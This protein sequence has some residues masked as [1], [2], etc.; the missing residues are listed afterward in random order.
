MD[1]GYSE[2]G[3]SPLLPDVVRDA[4]PLDATREQRGRKMFRIGAITTG[5]L[6]A[7]ALVGVVSQVSAVLTTLRLCLSSIRKENLPA[8]RLPARAHEDPRAAGRSLT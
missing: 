7:L 8:G 2:F 3:S 1:R 6:G 5:V 4:L